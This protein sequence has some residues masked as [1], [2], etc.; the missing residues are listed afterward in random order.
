MG[1]NG[2]RPCG[3]YVGSSVIEK[4]ETAVRDN[5]REAFQFGPPNWLVKERQRKGENFLDAAARVKAEYFPNGATMQPRAT[6]LKA[7]ATA[8]LEPETVALKRVCEECGKSILS[9]NL[10]GTCRS[11]R[12]R[13][14]RK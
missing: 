10:C 6:T 7:V 13:A 3:L 9:R 5:P 11:K 14:K 8:E 2:A 4:W 1:V 12:S